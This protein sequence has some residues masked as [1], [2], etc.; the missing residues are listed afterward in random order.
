MAGR[1]TRRQLVIGIFGSSG[2]ILA[3]S[4]LTACGGAAPTATPPVKG[5]PTA[6]QQSNQPA[7][8]A[9]TGPAA[10]APST[11]G[12]ASTKM[13]VWWGVGPQQKAVAA[14]FQKANA[15]IQVELAELGQN[16]YG[17]PKYLAA[18]AAGTGPDVAYQNRH[19]FH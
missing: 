14:D 8:T 12:Q 19:T 13:T 18:V 16:V 7:P 9:T 3:A 5:A 1:I 11:A 10:S 2:A 4:L 6:A 17:N 15:G